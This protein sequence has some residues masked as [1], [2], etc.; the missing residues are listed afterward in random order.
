MG[1][2]TVKTTDD[3]T[4]QDDD[5][6]GSAS[7]DGADSDTGAADVTD[8]DEEDDEEQEAAILATLSPAAVALFEKTRDQLAKA[9]ASSRNRRAVIKALRAGKTT[10]TGDAPKPKAPT[11]TEGAPAAFDPEAFMAQVRAE[12]KGEQDATRVQTAA[13]RELK[14]AGLVLPEDSAAAERKLSKV[15]RMLDL[16]GVTPD[17]V[18]DEVADLKADSPEL[19]GRR[20]TA[21]PKT[22]GVGGPATIKGGGTKSPVDDL[23]D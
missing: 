11:K 14:R 5:A 22:G 12:L 16:E 8:D 9:N 2:T 13:E 19:F 7:D 17:E 6:A 23:F 10:G 3:D 4:D 1:K 15:L 20:K 21:R 18:A